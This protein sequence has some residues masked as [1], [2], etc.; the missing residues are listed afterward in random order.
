MDPNSIMKH[1]N[2]LLKYLWT[3]KECCTNFKNLKTILELLH[4]HLFEMCGNVSNV[5]EDFFL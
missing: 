5:S 1:N 3:C 4:I 2:Y